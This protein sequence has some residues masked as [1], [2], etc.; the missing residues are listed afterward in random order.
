MKYKKATEN[1]RLFCYRF[2]FIIFPN[3]TERLQGRQ[4][5]GGITFPLSPFR[6]SLPWKALALPALSS[7]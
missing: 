6:Q 1:R 2:A 3:L 7:I 5:V 4:A